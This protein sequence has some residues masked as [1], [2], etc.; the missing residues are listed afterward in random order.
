METKKESN[1]LQGENLVTLSE[2]AN[3]FGG[4]PVPISTVRTY[5]YHGYKGIKLESIN[6]NGRYT[7]KEAIQRFIERKQKPIPSVEKLKVK[8]LTQAQI[9]AGLRKHEIVR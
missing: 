8:R 5:V 2:A 7:S 3:D 6:I 4:S 1:T 9:D